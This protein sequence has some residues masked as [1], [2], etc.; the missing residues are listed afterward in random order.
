MICTVQDSPLLVV[1]RAGRSPHCD[2]SR[3]H[4]RPD[5][6][7]SPRSL[8][9]LRLRSGLDIPGKGLQ[10][11]Q[12]IGDPIAQDLDVSGGHPILAPNTEKEHLFVGRLEVLG[13]GVKPLLDRQLRVQ[14]VCDQLIGSGDSLFPDS[15]QDG[16]ELGRGDQ[17]PVGVPVATEDRI[18]GVGHRNKGEEY[19]SSI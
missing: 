3:M 8:L 9:G 10:K 2:R 7:P 15:G 17:S 18:V 19:G 16:V 13:K 12:L 11:S 4:R 14:P 6:Q 1:T 5:I